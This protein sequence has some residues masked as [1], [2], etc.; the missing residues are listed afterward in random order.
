MIINSTTATGTA[1]PTIIHRLFC[2]SGEGSL[3]WSTAIKGIG[4]RLAL[5]Y[6]TLEVF[7]HSVKTLTS[8]IYLSDMNI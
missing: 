6:Q 7:N 8:K 4:K 3:T 5:M 1:T 2:D